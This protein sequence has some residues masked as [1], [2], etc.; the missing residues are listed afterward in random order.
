MPQEH[1][2][3]LRHVDQAGYTPDLDCYV[4]HGGYE[5]LRKAVAAAPRALPDGRVLD[6]AEQIRK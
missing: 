6:P 4:R 3:I 1:R 2:L 5:A